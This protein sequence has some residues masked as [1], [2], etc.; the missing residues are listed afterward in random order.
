MDEEQQNI[1]LKT[2]IIHVIPVQVI[3]LTLEH[4]R[5]QVVRMASN[6]KKEV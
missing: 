2:A 4:F 3:F 6:L 1:F 5:V